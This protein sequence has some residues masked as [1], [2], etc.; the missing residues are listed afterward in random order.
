ML[1]LCVKSFVYKLVK[2]FPEQIRFPYLRRLFLEFVKH[3]IHDLLRLLLR[4]DDRIYLRL[5][6]CANHVYRRSLC[7]QSDAVAARLL[8]DF[9]LLKTQIGNFR[10][11]DSVSP[12]VYHVKRFGVLLVIPLCLRKP[13]K[14]GKK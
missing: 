10:H 3:I 4:P 1:K 2:T 12:L 11:D 7:A 6:R 13:D 8:H 14:R 9:R 5:D